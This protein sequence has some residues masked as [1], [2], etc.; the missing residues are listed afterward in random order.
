MR[1][2]QERGAP[3]TRPGPAPEP[4]LLSRLFDE[5]HG[6]VFR[7]AYRVTGNAA[8]AEDVL[9]TVFLRLAARPDLSAITPAYLS[10]A[11]VNAGLDLV[12]ARGVRVTREALQALAE[13]RGGA[14]A[15]GISK[16]FPTAR[17]RPSSA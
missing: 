6:V 15:S 7:A 2:F 9:Q 11:G 3:M 1:I 5:H 17:S 8:D 10:R 12:R 16:G 14:S 4:T 13:A